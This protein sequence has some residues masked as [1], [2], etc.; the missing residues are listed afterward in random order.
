[1]ASVQKK[2]QGGVVSLKRGFGCQGRGSVSQLM[3]LSTASAALLPQGGLVG[4][5]RHAW[6]RD[7]APASLS[8]GRALG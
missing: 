3:L 4:C 1:M 7:S 6:N 8:T 2:G 5:P